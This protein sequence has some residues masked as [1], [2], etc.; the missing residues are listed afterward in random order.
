[1]TKIAR[2][3]IDIPLY[4]C[5]D[6]RLPD[7]FTDSPMPGVRIQVPFGKSQKIGVLVE[8]TDKSEFALSE[9][10]TVTEVL[11]SEAVITPNL[12]MLCQWAAHYYHAPLGEV[13][14]AALPQLLRQGR[15]ANIERPHVWQLDEDKAETVSVKRAPKQAMI[16][17]QLKRVRAGLSTEALVANG[18]TTQAIKTLEKKGVISSVE[19]FPEDTL[20][21]AKPSDVTLTEAQSHAVEAIKNALG[22]FKPILLEGV[23]GSGKTEVYLQLVSEV[24]SRGQQA[25]VLVPEI[26][27][28][29]QTIARF[30]ERFSVPVVSL[31]SGMTAKTRLQNW[32]QAKQG[33]AKIIIGTRSAV[34][35]P[36]ANLGLIVV[37]EEHDGSLKQQ[38][39][40]RYSARDLALVRGHH[41]RFP[42]IL[43]SA[44]PSLES[45]KNLDGKG[46]LHLCL[47]QRAGRA[48]MPEY[49]LVDMR[50]ESG[51]AVLSAPVI[52]AMQKT[53]QRGQQVLLF[54]NRR[55]FAPVLLCRSCGW[56]A[57]CL[58]C[59]AKLTL[60]HHTQ[61]LVCHHCDTTYPLPKECGACGHTKLA[62]LG[63]GT[64]RIEYWLN[65][66]FPDTKIQRIDRDSMSK[67]GALEASLNDIATGEPQ[68]LIGTQMLAKGHHFPNVTMVGILDVDYGLLST[69][70]KAME[71][72]GQLIVQV[73][74]RAGRGDKPG[75]VFIQSH[76]PE[77]PLLQV[78]VHEG[79]SAFAKQLIEERQQAG[80]PPF[81]HSVLLRA[82][83]PQLSTAMAFLERLKQS[84]SKGQQLMLWGPSPA[85]M[86]KRAGLYR[87]QLLVLSSN[88]TNLHRSMDNA[89]A[90]IKSMPER[91]KVRWSVD[92][93]PVDF[94]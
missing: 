70:F 19:C 5:F 49:H 76:Q 68:I 6:Y 54:L 21:L 58:R 7:T 57:T 14:A 66:H 59:D 77:H 12:M 79:Y 89:I 91:H 69:D 3:A 72:V 16:L 64:E 1:M 28:T 61:K 9:L 71:R 51:K 25:L 29:P 53:L 73:A 67:K 82:S 40:F 90:S 18:A 74:G 83:A 88:R 36:C 45:L 37:D 8:L 35:T 52:E 60:H 46:Y 31:H 65:E 80:L 50:L 41:E 86:T 23:T 20:G 39:G 48:I 62:P 26:S 56:I 81:C 43:G 63:H 87:A 38:E 42:V 93:D 15:P 85:S 94:F 2:V 33:E 92:V 27:L 24:L 30:E 32:L 22:Q 11:D 4:S 34:F 10:K 78:L 13:L 84:L 44:T 47:P 55:G 75:R 17:E